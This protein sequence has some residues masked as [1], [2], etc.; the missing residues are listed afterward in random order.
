MS[1]SLSL[2]KCKVDGDLCFVSIRD[3][4]KRTV[5]TLKFNSE[6]EAIDKYL[7]LTA[8][9]PKKEEPKEEPK[10]EAPKKRGRKKKAE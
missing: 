9:A 5:E 1:V 3:H 6:K 8:I 4:K 10:E 2:R 7:Q